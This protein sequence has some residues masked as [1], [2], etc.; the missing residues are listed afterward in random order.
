MDSDQE[1]VCTRPK[2]LIAQSRLGI[3]IDNPTP[4]PVD[5]GVPRIFDRRVARQHSSVGSQA[6]GSACFHTVINGN[7]PSSAMPK[8]IFI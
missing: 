1:R 8:E 3:A 7:K 6:F 2:T 4:I 5:A